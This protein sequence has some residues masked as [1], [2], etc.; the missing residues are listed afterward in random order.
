[1]EWTE[2]LDLVVARTGHERYRV[3]C[4]ADHPDHEIHRRRAIEK[5]TGLVARPEPQYPSLFR[6]AA[7]LAGAA[8]RAVGAAVRGEPVRAPDAVIEQRAAIC[9]P[10][11]FNGERRVP[12]R[13]RCTKCGCGGAKLTLATEAC[14]VGKWPAITEP[15][16]GPVPPG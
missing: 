13:I 7:N 15:P 5:A 1:M 4:A 14:P 11:E 16:S 10:C 8:V 6:Q 9:L 3:L 12:G 2:A